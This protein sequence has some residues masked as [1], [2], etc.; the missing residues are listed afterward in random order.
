MSC[1]AEIGITAIAEN[2]ANCTVGAIGRQLGYIFQYESNISNLQTETHSLDLEERKMKEL[3]ND[4]IR[5]GHA[6]FEITKDW[7]KHAGEIHKQAKEILEDKNHA[8]T[9]WC[10]FRGLLLLNLVPRYRLSKKAKKMCVSVVEIKGE[11]K[12]ENI[13]YRPHLRSDFTNKDYINFDS[14]NKIVDGILEALGDGNTRMIGVHGM[15]G[16]GKTTLVKEVSR[17]ALERE[18][19]SEAVLVPVSNT[20][21]V[22]KIQKAIAERLGLQL[23]EENI[24][25]RALRLQDRL[26]KEKKFLIILDD[27]WNKLKLED[28]GIVFEGDQTGC[29]ILFTS[30]FQRVLQDMG[31]VK[32][33]EVGLLEN[34]EALKW[35]RAIVA[36]TVEKYAE[37][38][39]LVN[40]IVVECAGLAITIETIACA[41]K[42]RT[43]DTWQDVLNQLKNSNLSDINSEV[44]E[45]VFKSIELCY[46]FVHKN[47]A[48]LL[49]LLCSLHGE[50]ES[51]RIE[52]LTRYCMGWGIF[53]NIHKLQDARV[54]VRS[55]IDDLK[56]RAL[57]LDGEYRHSVQMHDIVRDVAIS[58]A[59]KSHIYCF[60]D[61]SEVRYLESE[62]L[63]KSKAIM[64]PD[65]YVAELL[66]EG[67][68]YKQLELI[69]MWQSDASQIPD[70]FFEITKKLRVLYLGSYARLVKLPSSLCSLGN[71]RT[72]ILRYVSVEDISLIGGLRS[73]EILDL[74]RCGVK[75]LPREVGK[76]RC[77]RMLDLRGC[78]ELK[79][80]QPDVISN[81]KSLEELYV[82]KSFKGW[83]GQV[84][85]VNEDQRNA[86]LDELKLLERVTTVHL[87]IVDI[88]VLPKD[89]FRS[90]KLEQ[91]QIFIGCELTH[92]HSDDSSKCM[93]LSL[94]ENKLLDDYGL[95]RLLASTQALSLDGL[96]GAH[97]VVYELD[98]DGFPDLEHFQLKNNRTIQFLVESTE[99]IHPCSV[100]SRLETLQLDNLEN[101][102]EICD[103]ELTKE[104]FKRL[105]IIKV[106]SCNMLKNFLPFSMSKLEEFEIK[107]CGMMEEIFSDHEEED[108]SKEAIPE[109]PQLRSLKLKNV[110]RLKSFCSKLKKI[111]RSEKG[112]QPM[113]V[114]NSVKTLLSGKLVFLPVLEV[115]E[116]SNC[117]DLITRIRDDQILPSSASFHNLTKLLVEFYNSLE[118][119]FSS[120]V[121]TS[122]VQLRSL[123]VRH[124]SNMKE[125]VRNSENIVKMSFPKL[126]FLQIDNLERFATF[127]SEIDIDFPVLTELCMKDCPEF[128]TFI[129][130]SE[131]E[132][133]RSLF[134]EKVA[135]PSL[136]SVEIKGLVQL[137]MIWQYRL[138]TADSFS[139]LKYVKVENCNNLVKIFPSNMP[140]RLHNLKRLEIS[141][142]EMVEEVFE[143]EMPNVEGTYNVIP[144]ESELI[145]LSL[146]RLSKLKNVWSKDPQGTLTFPHLKEATAE[147]CPNLESIFPASI[148]KGLS[149]LRTLHIS[150]CGIEYIVGKEEGLETLPPKFQFHQLEEI[151][152]KNLINFVSFYQGLQ[153]CSFPLL[154]TLIVSECMKLKVIA[155]E[156]FNVQA[157]HGC[158]EMGRLYKLCRPLFIYAER[159]G[160][161]GVLIL[162]GLPELMQWMDESSQD[163]PAFKNFQI[164]QVWDCNMLKNLVPSSISF[165]NLE[166]LTVSRCHGMINLI[167]SQTAK[168]MNR[169][170][171]MKISYCLRLTEIISDQLEGDHDTKSGEI[172]FS[173]LKSLE[174]YM[175]P[176]LTSFNLGKYI[177]G[178]P[179][180]E[181]LVVYGCSAMQ[182]FSVYGMISTP[183]LNELRLDGKTTTRVDNNTVDIN[184]IIKHHFKSQPGYCGD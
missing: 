162:E 104:S 52:T 170:K 120:A 69:W 116:L 115:L 146:S 28:V 95:A 73:L 78:T 19:F 38:A 84:Q 10:T 43:L 179:E 177:M 30:R 111:Q 134:N 160:Y 127:S 118:Y 144:S 131:D 180:L 176:S 71:L 93:E 159:K 26:Q 23:D 98:K 163:H 181:S 81:L 178:F 75:E 117:N 147:S 123:V 132:K 154:T 88:K 58:I 57:L 153:T 155:S 21:D 138:S 148:A 76:L 103:G 169:L 167:S 101:L 47:E 149:Q 157:T 109:F 20:P 108:M 124:C 97:N 184:S 125:I 92:W 4:A 56:D 143:I 140:R 62:V 83:D 161:T 39:E 18:L 119:L 3:V 17:M 59:R 29:K 133:P 121:A 15:P 105:R 137:K 49:L 80:I 31:V 5:K 1:I 183:K 2:I 64:P 164:L 53:K 129:S 35:F 24:S 60:T 37:C 136:Q 102:E 158:V 63:E 11:V 173:G 7:Q 33:S 106:S 32:I 46:N 77:L 112:K 68:E 42:D 145:H 51:I 87:E 152:L 22:V 171:E 182:C 65:G 114:D 48:K 61:D 142:C 135:F 54:K 90:K 107:D 45:K 82:V 44:N 27:L 74:S 126:N 8:N 139:K 6:I 122:F 25:E 174:I 91:Y 94:D 86:S 70:R 100:F 40:D 41:L 72:L 34:A 13:S 168:S 150:D 89:L 130:K 66:R 12:F 151:R 172:V 128:S 85:G 14:R 141:D 55:L 50:D 9:G 166:M 99:Q 79:I 67:L 36:Q 175:L 113:D 16:V 96:Q 110:P 156:F 165:Q